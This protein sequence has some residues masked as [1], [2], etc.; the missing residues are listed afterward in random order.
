MYRLPKQN[1][2][3]LYYAARRT[4]LRILGFLLWLALWIGGALSYNH[5]H[6]TYPP[7]LLILGWRLFFL[8]LA[9]LV[10]GILIFRMWRLFTDRTCHGLIERSSL[11]RSYAPSG[12][13]HT[14]AD[15]DFRLNTKLLL[16]LENGKK[17]TL[18]FEQKNGF[19]HYYYEGNKIVR[20]RGLPYPILLDPNAPHGYVCAACGTWSADK[21]DRC[22]RCRHTVIDPKDLNETEKE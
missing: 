6:A 9:S 7:Q 18:C 17:K 8:V 11:S 10:S 2:D 19:Y 13:P 12:D 1:R 16:R 14:A 15:Y 3:L 22:A 21:T 4:L 20:F 5:N